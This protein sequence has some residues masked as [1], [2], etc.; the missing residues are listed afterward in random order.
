VLITWQVIM[1]VNEN[2]G[3]YQIRFLDGFVGRYV[4]LIKIIRSSKVVEW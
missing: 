1:Y 3:V 2:R 4:F